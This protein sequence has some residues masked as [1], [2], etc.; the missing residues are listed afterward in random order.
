L[1]IGFDG[2]VM[3]G[4]VERSRRADAERETVG[5]KGCVKRLVTGYYRIE[6]SSHGGNIETSTASERD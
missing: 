5:A 3:E 1:V 2:K 6:R 4:N